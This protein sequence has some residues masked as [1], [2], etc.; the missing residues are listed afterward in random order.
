MKEAIGWALV[1]SLWQ[2]LLIAGLFAVLLLAV[3]SPRIRYLAGCAALLAIL[4]SFAITLIHLLPASS[5]GLTSLLKPELPPWRP[6]P[7]ATGSANSVLYLIPR[8]T[9][10]WFT[11]VCLFYLHTAF[12][13]VSLHR[14]RSRGIY[15]RHSLEKLAS[16]LKITRTVLLLE[17]LL[18]DAPV[19]LGHFRPVILVP[20]GFLTG[21]PADPTT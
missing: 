12:G 14:L 3:R 9:P 6:L 5:D 10:V 20:L 17:S 13:W 21:L 16:E 15:N 2:G 4:L 11:G 8:L 7:D 19:V 1:H 18:A